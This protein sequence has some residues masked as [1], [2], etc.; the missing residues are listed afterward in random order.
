MAE[1]G[2][3]LS[4]A[5]LDTSGRRLF[6]GAHDGT[7]KMWNFSNGACLNSLAKH[8]KEISSLLHIPNSEQPIL[9]GGW[10]GR[11]VRWADIGSRSKLPALVHKEHDGEVHSI[12]NFEGIIATGSSDGWI[13]FWIVDSS[14]VIR[15]LRLPASPDCNESVRSTSWFLTQP[16]EHEESSHDN[17]PTL[18]PG[19]SKLKYVVFRNQIPEQSITA[20]IAGTSDGWLHFYEGSGKT[21]FYSRK[22]ANHPVRG[23]AV[24][25]GDHVVAKLV[26]EGCTRLVTVGNTVQFWDVSLFSR[27]KFS[28][29]L[30]KNFTPVEYAITTCVVS[31]SNVFV[32]ANSIGTVTIHSKDGEEIA[33]LG[34]KYQW[35]AAKIELNNDD[36]SSKKDASNMVDAN[37]DEKSQI[38]RDDDSLGSDVAKVT[39]VGAD[40]AGSSA[41]A[42]YSV[43]EKD[44]IKLADPKRNLAHKEAL[45]YDFKLQPP[46]ISL[47]V[48]IHNAR[49]HPHLSQA[50]YNNVCFCY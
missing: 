47:S 44:K 25:T 12:A 46:P 29:L 35:P 11:L 7:V 9:A 38:P 4:A 34:Q 30:I 6:T 39:S 36:S 45:S 40:L 41:P 48:F 33:T 42:L 28:M 5:I 31:V 8:N 2:S 43:S 49:M 19:V 22:V 26:L 17:T 14:P 24:D 3:V 27:K 13:L 18:V 37:E 21:P 10:E 32:L 50:F 23:I 15:R 20:L 1:H 16:A